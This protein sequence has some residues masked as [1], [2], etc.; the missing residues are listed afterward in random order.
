MMMKATMLRK[1]KS[2]SPKQLNIAVYYPWIYL[3]SGIER[4]ILNQFKYSRHKITLFTNHHDPKGTF[5]EFNL[6]PIVRLHQVP[7]KRDFSNVLTAALTILFQKIPLDIFDALVVHSEGLGDLAML[8]NASLPTVSICHTPIRPIYDSQ[9]RKKAMANMDVIRQILL[10]LFSGTYHFLN[11]YLWKQYQFICFNSLETQSRAHA[12][13]LISTDDK[14]ARVLHPGIDVDHRYF[15]TTNSHYFLVSGRIMWT[16]QIEM[17]IESFIKFKPHES[18]NDYCLVIAGSVDAKSRPYLYSLQEAAAGRSDIQFVIDPTDY[19]LS[20]LYSKAAAGLLCSFNEDWG[21][22][23]LE[24][25]AHGK[26]VIAVNSGG[27]RESISSNKTGIL[28]NTANEI[29]EAMMLLAESPKLAKKMGR[30][31]HKYVINNHQVTDYIFQ[32]DNIINQ[33]VA[34]K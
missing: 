22:T 17:A 26:P 11:K 15:S 32:L 5:S 20:K 21:L 2:H 30:S 14:R 3:K 24:A 10:V 1:N 7:V 9:Y 25:N 34:N 18:A 33:A 13:G 16:K 23:V 12:A 6:I 28:C 8:R 27:P 31:A 29:S 19:Q 4:T